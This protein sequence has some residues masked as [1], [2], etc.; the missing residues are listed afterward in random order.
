MNRGGGCV[1]TPLSPFEKQFVFVIYLTHHRNNSKNIVPYV[2][3]GT[4]TN[5]LIVKDNVHLVAALLVHYCFS[6]NSRFYQP[7][8]HGFLPWLAGP[9]ERGK[10]MGTRLQ[11]LHHVYAFMNVSGM[12]EIVSLRVK[13]VILPGDGGRGMTQAH[14]P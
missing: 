7:R 13:S 3:F 6:G 1:L 10:A 11:I 9:P 2:V 4:S 5:S 8:S 12:L 14:S